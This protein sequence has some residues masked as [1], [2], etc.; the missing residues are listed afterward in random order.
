MLSVSMHRGLKREASVGVEQ[1]QYCHH[2]V[3]YHN[4]EREYTLFVQN[5]K[6]KICLNRRKQ[7]V[8]L[9]LL[10][11]IK[12]FSSTNPLQMKLITENYRRKQGP[13]I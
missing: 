3:M 13:I 4:V 12:D 5:Q 2:V 1:M 10:S 11:V 8:C 7:A 9:S 6:K